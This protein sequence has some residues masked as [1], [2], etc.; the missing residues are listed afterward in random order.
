M[1]KRLKELVRE[2]ERQGWT[3]E[4]RR[5]GHLKWT[6]PNGDMVFSPST[7]SDYRGL[8]NL[9]RDLRHRGLSV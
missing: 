8:K 2:A 4:I 3:V 6:A 5:S 9:T 1:K 7:P